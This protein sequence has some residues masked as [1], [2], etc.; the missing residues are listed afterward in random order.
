[1]EDKYIT[2]TQLNKYLRYKF[3]NDSNLNIVYLKGE[4]SNFKAHSTGHLYFTIKDESSRVGAIMFSSS[5][6]KLKFDLE[7][8]M[9]V[10]V[11]GKVSVYEP[12]GEYKFYVNELMI[13]GLGN[14]YLEYEKLKKFLP[15]AIFEREMMIV[16]GEKFKGVFLKAFLKYVPIKWQ[17]P[18]YKF[19]SK[20]INL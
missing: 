17:Y 19:F 20:P 18:I 10:L 7:D 1:M 15:D 12:T 6:S 16:K 9:K 8:G 14:L 5:A 2:V 13:D 3:E 4:I 11:K